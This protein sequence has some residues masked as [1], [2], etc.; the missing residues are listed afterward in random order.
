MIEYILKNMEEIKN[1]KKKKSKQKL[2][3]K[4]IYWDLLIM[5]QTMKGNR[6]I[7]IRMI[8]ES[9]II[10]ISFD[11]SFVLFSIIDFPKISYELI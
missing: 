1:P 8:T 5:L 9:C 10:Q 3:Y 2:M 11:F 6:D 4:N 7:S